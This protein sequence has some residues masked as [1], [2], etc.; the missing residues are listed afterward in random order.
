ML[1]RYTVQYWSSAALASLLST[2][3]SDDWQLII[4]VQKQMEI[5]RI[6][7]LRRKEI[8]K[9]VELKCSRY[10]QVG[11]EYVEKHLPMVRREQ[12]IDG[13]QITRARNLKEKARHG[14]VVGRDKLISI[15]LLTCFDRR[16]YTYHE[17][18]LRARRKE[19]KL[20]IKLRHKD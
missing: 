12:R 3:V 14:P 4:V 19:G 18:G 15:T 5:I 6:M 2:I 7:T 20:A 9:L 17:H 13:A 1:Q 11:I 8:V 10:N 16:L